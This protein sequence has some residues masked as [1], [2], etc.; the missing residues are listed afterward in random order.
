[1]VI[2]G[3]P[4]TW[5]IRTSGYATPRSTSPQHPATRGS[6]RRTDFYVGDGVAHVDIFSV[7]SEISLGRTGGGAGRRRSVLSQIDCSIGPSRDIE[8]AGG[9]A[10]LFHLAQIGA[11]AARTRPLKVPP[12]ISRFCPVM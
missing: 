1:M 5:P 3:W 7:G 8:K 6:I 12:S 2:E 4:S 11:Y 9:D 10:G